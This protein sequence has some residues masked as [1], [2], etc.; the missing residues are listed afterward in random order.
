MKEDI[1]LAQYKCECCGKAFEKP[2]I[3]TESNNIEGHIETIKQVL[4]PFCSGPHFRE[5]YQN[6]DRWEW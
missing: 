3:I 4:C 1:T 5:F 2:A 6:D